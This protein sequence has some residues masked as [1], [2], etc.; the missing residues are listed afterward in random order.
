MADGKT[1]TSNTFLFGEVSRFRNEPANSYF[2]FGNVTGT[3][4]GPPWTG[5]SFWPN[6]YRTGDT[7]FVVPRLN[8]PP[9]TTGA[10]Y[11]ACWATAVLPPDWI[12]VVACQNYGQWAFR[13][14]HPG[15]GNFAIADGSVKFIKNSINLPTYRALGTRAGGEVISSDSY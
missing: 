3:F 10:V 2:N 14:N 8:S 6:D 13:S 12:N 11:A 4:Q 9:D 1:G 7:G 5:S 15:G